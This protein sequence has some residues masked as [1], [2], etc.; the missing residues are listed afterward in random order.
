MNTFDRYLRTLSKMTPVDILLA[1]VAIRIQLSP[2]D[3][4]T[5]V[6]HFGAIH[7]YIERPDSPLFGLVE[8]FYVQGGFSIGAVVARHATDDEFDLDAMI[9]LALRSDIDPEWALATLHKAIRGA[10]GS[11]YFDR[12]ERKTRCSTVFYAGMHVDVTP[13]VRLQHLS[14]KTGLIFHSKPEDPSVPRQRLYANPF[15]FAEWFKRNTPTNADFG[16]FFESLSLDQDR[17][18]ARLMA[19]DKAIATPVPEHA[20]AYRKSLAVIALQLIKRWRNLAYDRRHADMRLPP[21]VLLAFYVA[22]NAN[23]T[24][25]LAAELNHQVDRLIATFDNAQRQ[26]RLVYVQNPECSLDVFT[27]RWP[28]ELTDQKVFLDEL[29]L[30]AK[31]LQR[32]ETSDL[33]EMQMILKDLFGEKPAQTAVR[34]YAEGVANDAGNAGARYLSGRAAIPAGLAGV[35][36]AP[37]IARASTPGVVRTAPSHRFFGDDV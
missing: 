22:S 20:P 26:G 30:F 37:S 11:R 7:D 19:L 35:A 9:Q 8:E 21:S 16:A 12:C 34:K 29:R 10:P 24:T 4:Q 3:H 5:A 2:T 15:G 36:A 14:E 13:T 23:R 31:K 25:S 33:E 6:D 18:R 32:L 17:A 27:D 28:G 1:E